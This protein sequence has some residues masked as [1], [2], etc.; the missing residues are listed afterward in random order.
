MEDK[1]TD[2]SITIMTEM[3]MPN[4]TN[5]LHNLMGGN[6][7]RWMDVAAGICAR[8]HANAVCVT[9]AVDNVSFQ[10]P[11]K[12]GDA[13]TL[14]AKVTRAFNT[15]MEI[16]IVVCTENSEATERVQSNEAYFT[17]VALD[18]Y[19]K[20]RKIPQ[21]LIEGE[22]EKKQ[23]DGAKRRREMRLILSG[24]MKPD[25]SIELKELFLK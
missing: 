13:V 5:P 10:N 8:R 2:K 23:Y 17:F 15:S 3:V 4:D 22:E 12:L 16:H 19:G 6:L 25:Q 1:H 18:R 9:A 21:L 24:R 20:P 14:T 11:I 7:L